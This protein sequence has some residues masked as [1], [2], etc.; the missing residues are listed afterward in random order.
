MLRLPFVVAAA[1]LVSASG[2]LA[3]T[4]TLN[5]GTLALN[6]TGAAQTDVGGT[7]LT[8]DGYV[9]TYIDLSAPTPVTFTADASGTSDGT[10]KPDMTFSI[11]DSTMSFAVGSN[12]TASTFTTPT[13]PAGTYF[14]RTQLD[15][16]P[17]NGSSMSLNIS[18]L[19][20]DGNGVTVEN[21]ND[22]P[23]AL[24]AATTYADNFRSGLATIKLEGAGGVHLPAGISVQAKLVSNAFNFD[25]AVY[26]NNTGDAAWINVRT[27]TASLPGGGTY[28]VGT[29]TAPSGPG[30]AQSFQNALLDPK[31]GINGIV[32]SNGG[33]WS[34]NEPNQGQPD[35]SLVD[36]MTQ[37]ANQHGLGMRM[38]NLIWASQQ[39]DFINNIFAADG[40]TLTSTDLNAVNSA[41]TS[42]INYYASA[43]NPGTG[44]PS[45]ANYNEMDV[46]NEPFHDQGSLVNYIAPGGLGVSGVANVYQQVANAVKSAGAN[47]RLYTNEFNVLQFSPG[48]IDSQGNEQGSDPYANWYRQGVQQ[49]QAAGGPVSG[50]G[51]E[52]YTNAGNPVSPGEMQEAI[53]NMSVAKDPNG[54]PM[55][56]SLTEFGQNGS[57]PD[58]V[59]YDN[60]LITALTM[61]YGS[62]QATTFGFWGGLGGPHYDGNNIYALEDANYNLTNAGIDWE[63]WMSQWQTNVS[64]TTDSNG[65]VNFN[66]TYGEYQIAV[67]GK[68]YLLDVQKGITSYTLLTTPEPASPAL[69]SA[70]GVLL[71]ARRRRRPRRA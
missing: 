55:P 56:L 37:F 50:I 52:L 10:T 67:G 28:T 13:L 53:Q 48:S 57:Q 16:A 41:I 24:A 12:T 31:L 40:G 3:Q 6:S 38:H 9:G 60:D 4:V 5:G 61:M 36:A 46:L 68:T 11:A 29:Y 64:L 66:G 2:S 35:M 58:E 33:K 19:K 22:D 71:C 65:D 49:I 44:K 32:P 70:T 30:E 23:T 21:T 39:P 59:E 20:I 26:G 51:M 17:V 43:I 25:V 34:N 47:T 1:V 69:A 18:D 63:N 27:G 45:V 54:N 8:S 7:T 15:N 62:P 14:V 42:R